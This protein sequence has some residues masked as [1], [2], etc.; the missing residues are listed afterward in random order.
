M[1]KN[2]IF[3]F[4]YGSSNDL[5][6]VFCECFN[7]SDKFLTSFKEKAMKES[8]VTLYEYIKQQGKLNY[9]KEYEIVLAHLTTIDKTFIL[10]NGLKSLRTLVSEE[11]NEINEL[12]NKYDLY[13]DYEN[14]CI[15]YNGIEYDMEK[16][17]YKLVE[18]LVY[19][20]GCLNAFIYTHNI[21]NYNKAICEAPE[22]LYKLDFEFKLELV[23]EWKKRH[24]TAI[25]IV[26]F[27]K[28]NLSNLMVEDYR[29]ETFCMIICKMI[30]NLLFGKEKSGGYEEI[31]LI[32]DIKP[33]NIIKIEDV[34][35]SICCKPSTM[36]Y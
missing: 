2:K 13:I 23:D 29:G 20:N 28:T 6:D 34:N 30:E 19:E 1:N 25:P 5:L 33:E 24:D 4:Y 17:S 11:D 22:I 9:S 36:Y 14:T 26:V 10:K 27:F 21:T 16:L 7:I 18:A 15:N 8:Y 32:N 12:L 31:G 35:K 3:D